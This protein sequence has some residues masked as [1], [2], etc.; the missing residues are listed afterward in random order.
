MWTDGAVLAL[1]S[2]TIPRGAWELEPQLGAG[3]TRSTLEGSEQSGAGRR[4]QATLGIL[5]AGAAVRLR[6]GRWSFGGTVGA[7]WI[8]GTPT[9]TRIGSSA[10][11]FRV[12]GF[13]MALGVLAAADFGGATW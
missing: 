7:D 6:F 10:E 5:R 1:T 12:P 3:V 11:I 8:L 9:Y 4:E 2:W 13:A